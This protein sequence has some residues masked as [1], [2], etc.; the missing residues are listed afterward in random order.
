MRASAPVARSSGLRSQRAP[1]SP[2]TFKKIRW[3]FFVQ[4]GKT[5]AEPTRPWRVAGE[6]IDGVGSLLPSTASFSTVPGDSESPAVLPGSYLGFSILR[7]PLCA[8]ATW[9][10][11]VEIAMVRWISHLASRISY[12]GGW[13]GGWAD[14]WFLLDGPSTVVRAVPGWRSRDRRG[15]NER[16]PTRG[17]H[18]PR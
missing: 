11:C 17:R 13:V 5:K 10:L 9:R 7:L 4:E 18:G 6:K 14:L 15:R 1:A 8:L 12:P 2:L 16:G 3:R